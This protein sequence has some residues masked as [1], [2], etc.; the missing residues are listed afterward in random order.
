MDLRTELISLLSPGQ[1]ASKL[2]FGPRPNPSRFDYIYVKAQENGGGCWY[3]LVG[4][5]DN[6]REEYLDPVEQASLTGNLIDITLTSV[7]TTFGV[8]VKVD[9]MFDIG[10]DVPVVVRS[11]A[12]TFSE[13]VLRSL[14][15]AEEIVNPVTLSLA[16]ADQS[17]KAIFADLL[18]NGKLL[19]IE[20]GMPRLITWEKQDR[21]RAK[22]ILETFLPAVNQ[23]RQK[24]GLLPISKPVDRLDR[25]EPTTPAS[26]GNGGNKSPSYQRI[27]ETIQKLQWTSEQVV[28]CL[29]RNYGGRQK[30]SLLDDNEQA[31]FLKILELAA[32]KL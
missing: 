24:L 2:G 26:N 32:E 14:L 10:T 13:S 23:I 22:E 28:T 19:T 6:Q 17:E 18:S 31:D 27:A 1:N 29:E 25:G 20:K 30:V 21:P 7:T 9:L 15:S 8:Q 4:T 11:G 12:S 16:R 5:R 3:R